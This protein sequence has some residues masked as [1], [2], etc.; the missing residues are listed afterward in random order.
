MT[1]QLEF[2]AAIYRFPTLLL[3]YAWCL[4]WRKSKKLFPTA[5][6]EYRAVFRKMHRVDDDYLSMSLSRYHTPCSTDNIA[7]IRNEL[8]VQ[9]APLS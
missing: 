3:M 8:D 1:L 5:L 7:E 6:L 2:T 4:A 9:T